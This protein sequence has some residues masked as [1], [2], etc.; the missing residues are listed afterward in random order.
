MLQQ[1]NQDLEIVMVESPKLY[2]QNRTVSFKTE[3]TYFLDLESL[4]TICKY[5][6]TY[7]IIFATMTQD[8]EKCW[9]FINKRQSSA[10]P[11]IDQLSDRILEVLYHLC[12]TLNKTVT[13]FSLTLYRVI[14]FL[15]LFS[16][17]R[18]EEEINTF[19]GNTP[20]RNQFSLNFK[21]QM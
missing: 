1:S 10:T 18:I 17:Q 19:E 12:F 16:T 14:I 8:S 3:R 15:Q 7:I 13:T 9:C 6:H 21:L 5:P 4:K 11:V 2:P 20:N